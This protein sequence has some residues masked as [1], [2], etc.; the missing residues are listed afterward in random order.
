MFAARSTSTQSNITH[1][2]F[3]DGTGAPTRFSAIMS[4]KVNGCFA[5]G[6]GVSG[7]AVVARKSMTTKNSFMRRKTLAEELCVQALSLGSIRLWRV[8]FGVPSK[9][10]F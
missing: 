10:N 4:S 6:D 3:G 1:L 9:K 5:E 8:G 7:K 2:P